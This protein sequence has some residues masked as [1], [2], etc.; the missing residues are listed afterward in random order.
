MSNR[1]MTLEEFRTFAQDFNVIPVSRR[2][3]ADSQT[4]LSLYKK[5]A[6]DRTGTFLLESAEHGGVW[7]RYSFIG[8]KSESTLTERDGLATWIG[9]VPSGAPSGIDPIEALKVSSKHLRSPHIPHL[10]SIDWWAS[11]L[12]K[13]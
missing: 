2:Y 6:Q 1:E 11:W 3:L 5:L 7:S 8:I 12:R 13:L 9:T 4:P 10:P